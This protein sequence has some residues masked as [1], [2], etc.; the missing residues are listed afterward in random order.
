M[1]SSGEDQREPGFVSEIIHTINT[2]HKYSDDSEIMIMKDT[3]PRHPMS[4]SIRVKST[5]SER[6]P[7]SFDWRHNYYPKWKNI[8]DLWT[9]FSL[10][11]KLKWGRL[12]VMR[13]DDETQDIIFG[14]MTNEDIMREGSDEVILSHLDEI[15]Q[16]DAAL[17]A[18]GKY[19]Q[20][21]HFRRPETMSIPDYI[22]E[23]ERRW[24]R[25]KATGTHVA[26]N[27]LALCMLESANLTSWEQNLVRVTVAEFSTLSMKAKLRSAF[28]G[29]TKYGALQK[30]S[31][32]C[33]DYT[34]NQR[35]LD[36]VNQWVF[37]EDTDCEDAAV[38]VEPFNGNDQCPE[39]HCGT[40][41]ADNNSET[42]DNAYNCESEVYNSCN[43][44]Y[45]P[46]YH[47]SNHNTNSLVNVCESQSK[48]AVVSEQ[49]L[50]MT[51][52]QKVKYV[53]SDSAIH[54]PRHKSCR[55]HR[56]PKRK[57]N[58]RRPSFGCTQFMF[59]HS[60]GHYR[61]LQKGR[62][63]DVSMASETKSK[64]EWSNM[65]RCNIGSDV[66]FVWKRSR[67]KFRYN[68]QTQASWKRRK[69]KV[70]T[71]GLGKRWKKKEKVDVI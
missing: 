69:K 65:D 17:S 21:K 16:E 14:K 66:R 13:L 50:V 5:F 43:H 12:L 9:S 70:T 59:Y 42:S 68:T 4:E 33:R 57:A 7:P 60:S 58:C 25:T 11:P 23:F 39:F 28:A 1:D 44:K 52:L 64:A 35:E 3:H 24:Q 54:V 30:V 37:Q 32:A 22:L 27:V 45:I 61:R 8:Y 2:S 36:S 62:S 71:K 29:T 67:R 40:T 55:Y 10:V 20:F 53:P 19:E 46:Q 31:T 48:Q 47:D 51:A 63:D 41:S 56:L 18:Y 15:F 34:N 38:C 6:I 26:D 49:M